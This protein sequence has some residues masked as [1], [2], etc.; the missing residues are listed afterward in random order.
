MRIFDASN[1]FWLTLPD[2]PAYV[3]QRNLAPGGLLGMSALADISV[4]IEGGYLTISMEGG[5]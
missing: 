3:L 5:R 4:G 1:T 2:V